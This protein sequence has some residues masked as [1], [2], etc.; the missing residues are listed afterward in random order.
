MNKHLEQSDNW[1]LG[2]VQEIDVEFYGGKDSM[3]AAVHLL[4]LRLKS[5]ESV[6]LIA[7]LREV[8]GSPDAQT[9]SRHEIAFYRDLA[10]IAGVDS[11]ETYIAE[12]DVSTDRM[13]LVQEYLNKGS[14]GAIQT[15]LS[16]DDLD[17]VLSALAV[18]HA[19]WWNSEAL[20][21]LTQIRTFE[22]AMEGGA[23]QFK[24]GR[25]SG[26]QFLEKYGE[27]VH[28]EI[29]SI[30]GSDYQWDP[31]FQAGFSGNRT[32]CHYDVAAK[33]LFLPEDRSA[34]PVF[35]DWELVIRGN[36]GVELAQALA[37]CMAPEDHI[38]IPKI[39]DDYLE[40][41]IGLGVSDL[42]QE[43]LWSDFRH[44]LLVRLAAPIALSS[45]GRP[46]STALALEILPRI[47]SAV[48]ATNALELLE[49]T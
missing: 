13:L 31:V 15:Y 11:P 41:M 25:Y 45:R 48:L 49:R 27:Y 17:R 20:A 14:V 35:F 4:K 43:T 2:P 6:S 18:M 3:S 39:L 36:I 40:K 12:Y 46:H 24:S 7:K 29:A 5:G 16:F 21:Q 22:Q 28:P 26:R 1:A 38:R 32:L 19:K 10:D 23:R 42:T 33:N 44:G 47:T 8:G 34:P 30:Y 9:G 37:Y